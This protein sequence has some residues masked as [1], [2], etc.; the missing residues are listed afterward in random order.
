MS[1]YKYWK[2]NETKG[3]LKDILKIMKPNTF[4]QLFSVFNDTP[5]AEIEQVLKP[6]KKGYKICN[7]IE[8]G[9]E[10][11]TMSEWGLL[12]SSEIELLHE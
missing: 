11:L 8:F 5:I 9:R 3:E 6:I 12:R 4:C 7:S 2:Y 1:N 10:N